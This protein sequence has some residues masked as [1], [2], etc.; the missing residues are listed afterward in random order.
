MNLGEL[1]KSLARF[2]KDMDNC[3]MI[4]IT[5]DSQKEREYHLLAGVG[6]PKEGNDKLNSVMLVSEEYCQKLIAEGKLET[7]D[8]G[9]NDS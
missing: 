7:Q 5:L 3:H 4:L 2:P 8:D 6:V 9:K 1:K